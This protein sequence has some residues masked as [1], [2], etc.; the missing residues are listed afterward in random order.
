MPFGHAINSGVHSAIGRLS[1]N[2]GMDRRHLL[3]FAF[4]VELRART[5]LKKQLGAV[6]E[7]YFR[8]HLLIF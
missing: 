5:D 2:L 3:Q 7:V 8:F 1:V 6:V 4:R